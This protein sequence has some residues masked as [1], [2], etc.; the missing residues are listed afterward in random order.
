[1]RVLGC[2]LLSLVV[3]VCYRAFLFV[4][5]C[6]C[7]WSVV[8]LL[9]FETGRGRLCLFVV[10]CGRLLW[11]VVV[12]CCVLLCVVV[13]CCCGVVLCGFVCS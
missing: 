3:I 12:R 1:M 13:V 8:G 10:V 11:C 2:V 9:M 7:V 6:S 4:L 5:V